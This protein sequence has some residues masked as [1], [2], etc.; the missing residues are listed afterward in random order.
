MSGTENPGTR[1][2]IQKSA[3]HRSFVEKNQKSFE[4]ARRAREYVPTG[5][6]RA[7][8]KHPPFPFYIAHAE[9]VHATDLDD[10]TRIDFHNN[11]TAQI[12]GHAHPRINAAV[13]H[14]LP[15]GTA[16]SAPGAQE[17]ELAKLLCERIGS[18]EQVV[19]NNSGSEAVMVALRCARA[20]TGRNR[21]GLFEG[22]YHGASDFVMVGGHDLPAPEDPRGITRPAPDVGGL[23]L[24]ATEDAVL[25]RY[26]DPQA[27]REAVS[28]Y[29]SELAAILVEPLLGASGVI[30]ADAEFLKVIREE[31][32]RAGIVFICDEVVT[33]RLALGGAQGYYGVQPDLT[34]MAKIIGGGFPIGAVG[35][36]REFMRR[37]GEPEE[38]GMVANLGTFSANPI[39]VC[40]GF[41]AMQMLDEA[42]IGHINE[43]G[44]KARCGITQA[45]GRHEAPAQ[46]TGAGSLFQIHW[47][48]LPVTDARR[49]HTGDAELTLLAFLGLCNRG[50]HLSM[51]GMAAVSTPM[52]EDHVDAL[53]GAFDDTLAELRSEGWW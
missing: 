3:I 45:I 50:I 16:Y 34:T 18:I 7:L 47:T 5:T 38:G 42:A 28:R 43:L 19:F 29:G 49:A 39:S 32:E 31:T 10:N 15:H 36:R 8:L 24:A 22:A 37:F 46:V 44:E 26:N 14:Q 21:I 52:G 20:H 53:T 35:G 13:E 17:Y 6:S 12:H 1:R 48:T 27:V 4:H 2:D 9:G 30:P 25:I 23:P 40:A 11:Y 51:R 41:E 33:L